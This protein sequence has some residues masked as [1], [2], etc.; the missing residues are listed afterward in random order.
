MKKA[1]LI[2]QTSKQTGI[3]K[4]DVMITLEALLKKIK[5]S[6]S[7]G[8]NVYLRG[9]GSFINKKRA[10]K[11]GRNIKKNKIVDIPAHYI[12]AFR[13]SREFMQEIRKIQI[14]QVTSS[15]VQHTKL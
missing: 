7:A 14:D 13:P 4:V 12:P 6:L 11:K 15:N 2:L 3:A 9:F 5:E 1:D 8:E 10:A